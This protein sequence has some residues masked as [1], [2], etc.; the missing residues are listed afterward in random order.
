MADML[1]RYRPGPSPEATDDCVQY[2]QDVEPYLEE[3]KRLQGMEQNG[4]FRKVANIPHVVTMQW[5]TEDGIYW[6]SLPKKEKGEYLRRK[7][8]DPQYMYLKTIDGNV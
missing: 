6:P 7:L 2:S 5:M 3:N 1:T 8:N 4:F